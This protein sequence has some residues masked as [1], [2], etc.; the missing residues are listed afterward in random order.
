[1]DLY[2]I[3]F[4]KVC[5]VTNSVYHGLAFD[6]KA[7]INQHGATCG[8]VKL[9]EQPIQARMIITVYCLY[10]ASTVVM[11]NRWKQLWKLTL[12]HKLHIWY[13]RTGH[14]KIFCGKLFQNNRGK[15]AKLLALLD[16]VQVRFY[17][18]SSGISHQRT[19]TKG[20]RAELRPPI[21]NTEN[22]ILF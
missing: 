5:R 4:G 16:F 15:W 3:V 18:T 11:H 10:S 9:S 14:I 21:C 19:I 13:A 22:F 17:V 8:I 12:N 20:A 2:T 7:G 1:M 6:V